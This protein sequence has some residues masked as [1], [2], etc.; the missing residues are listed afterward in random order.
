MRFDDLRD[1]AVDYLNRLETPHLLAVAAAAALAVLAFWLLR[2]R[3]APPIADDDGLAIDLA[4]L[5]DCRPDDEDVSLSCYG[6]PVRLAVLV[7]APSGRGADVPTGIAR[8]AAIDQIVPGL[9]RV[10]DRHTTL[11][12]TWPPQLSPRGFA[13]LLFAKMKLPGDFGR[14][15]PWCS[16][17]GKFEAGGETYMVGMALCAA[18]ENSLSNIIVGTP[19]EWLQVLRVEHA[20]HAEA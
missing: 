16:L 8:S 14:G 2:G 11:V 20:R 15:T 18:R 13:H 3:R 7:L 6:V 4:S 19:G 5:G 9:A 17:A 10:A 12:K 1:F